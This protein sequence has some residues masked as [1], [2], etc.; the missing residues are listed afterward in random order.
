[1]LSNGIK[2]GYSIRVPLRGDEC[3]YAGITLHIKKDEAVDLVIVTRVDNFDGYDEL[4]FVSVRA[5]GLR[6]SD[7]Q[8][9]I[10]YIPDRYRDEFLINKLND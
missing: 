8:V 10:L 5:D 3:Y 6:T 2:T 7:G 4:N 1:M 9:N